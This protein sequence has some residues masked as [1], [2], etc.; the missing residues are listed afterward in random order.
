MYPSKW[1]HMDVEF[2]IVRYRTVPGRTPGINIW[3]KSN[4]K[5]WISLSKKLCVILLFG[6]RV[7]LT[8]GKENWRL[9]GSVGCDVQVFVILIPIQ[10]LRN[11]TYCSFKVSQ[12]EQQVNLRLSIWPTLS[13]P[14]LW[15]PVLKTN[16]MG[17]FLFCFGFFLQAGFHSKS[18]ECVH[19]LKQGG[20]IP[21]AAAPTKPSQTLIIPPHRAA[22]VPMD[23]TERTHI[24]LQKL[25]DEGETCRHTDTRSNFKSDLSISESQLWGCKTRGFHC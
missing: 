10:S 14:L 6:T 25:E 5:W 19:F 13:N 7:K 15:I 22:K 17:V 12:Q 1:V 3:F 16:Q 2:M 9:T 4:I 20:K 23:W 18:A 8:E 24:H 11:I 21:T